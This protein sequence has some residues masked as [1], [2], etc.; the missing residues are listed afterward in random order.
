MEPYFSNNYAPNNQHIRLYKQQLFIDVRDY[1]QD[2]ID[3]GGNME[4][5][6]LW[7]NGQHT[8]SKQIIYKDVYGNY[9]SRSVHDPNAKWNDYSTS[10][11]MIQVYKRRILF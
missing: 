2:I 9:K 7:S 8:A 6:V 3:N 10:L 4:F 1:Q 11:Q 5:T